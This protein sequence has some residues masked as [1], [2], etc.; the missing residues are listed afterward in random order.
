[1]KIN[2][3]CKHY[4]GYIPCEPHKKYGVHCDACEHYQMIKDRIL[5]I[6]L[7]AAGDVIR[8]TPLL[9]RIW[10]EMPQAHITWLT[11]FP[12]LIPQ[13][14][15]VV[16]DYSI[17]NITWLLGREF[18]LIISLDK[19][20]EAISVAEKIPAK[21]KYG[22]GMDSF[23]RCRVFNELS[24][25]KLETGLF[26][27]V[28]K[29]NSKSYPQEIFELCGY[30][31]MGEEY[32]LD[33]SKVHQWNIDHSKSIVGLNTGCGGRWTSRLWSDQNW[34]SLAR[35]LRENNFE[36]I[37]LGG[38]QE[39]NK[40]KKYQSEGGGIYAGYFDLKEFVSLMDEC[41]IVVSQVT[42]AMHIAIG[43][44]KNLIL[45]NNIFNKNEFEL[46]GRGEII[47]PTIP[48]GCYYTPVCPHN[49]MSQI[50]PLKIFEAVK[51]WV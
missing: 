46:Y 32:I 14:V 47:E 30:N 26:D 21:N 51:N 6:K 17:K 40:N 1:M 5:I 18:D 9:K 48:C 7:G 43:L 16:V 3:D 41:D 45:M 29:R 2:F 15:D 34:I 8:T 11:D 12:D 13:A 37:W 23:G 19:D 39:D 24:N 38:R 20:K 36:V 31:F 27:D 10:D 44:K 28:S 35:T 22:F 4:K 50:T 25:H 33:V 49:S 42:M